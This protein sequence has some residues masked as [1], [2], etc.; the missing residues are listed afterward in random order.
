M[1]SAKFGKLGCAGTTFVFFFTL[2]LFVIIGAKGPV[3]F[4]TVRWGNG[5]NVD[6]QIMVNAPHSNGQKFTTWTG[7]VEN[8]SPDMQLMWMTLK[9]KRPATLKKDDG[10]VFSQ[11]LGVEV[12]GSFTSFD[13]VKTRSKKNI[14]DFVIANNTITRNPGWGPNRPFTD[15]QTLYNL[16]VLKY[17]YYKVNV[18]FNDVPTTPYQFSA[19][20]EMLH[21]NSQYTKFE[22][23]WKYTLLVITILVMIFPRIPPPPQAGPKC[24]VVVFVL[25]GWYTKLCSYKSAMWTNQQKWI[26]VLLPALFLFNDPLVGAYADATGKANL[27]FLAF[28]SVIFSQTFISLLL[29]FWICILEE[30]SEPP[31]H[32]LLPTVV[33]QHGVGF[34]IEKIP[35]TWRKHFAKYLHALFFWIL[36]VSSYLYYRFQQRADPTYTVLSEKRGTAEAAAAFTIIWL[37][38][39]CLWFSYY[40]LRGIK[41]IM[42]LKAGFLLVYFLTVVT[43]IAVISGIASGAMFTLNGGGVFLGVYGI[44]NIYIWTLAFVYA[45]LNRGDASS[46]ERE[47]VDPN[48][49]AGK[50]GGLA[51]TDD[52]NANNAFRNRQLEDDDEL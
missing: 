4:K 23:G 19:V 3:P 45:P 41:N 29:S 30:M 17:P 21:V 51:A 38:G 7:T 31:A 24:G 35:P 13:D 33:L 27:E 10:L 42:H 14:K 1:E 16:L 26:S 36:T 48:A 44:T 2:F 5:T 43:A 25:E 8:I 39:Y 52:V 12:Y 47:V 32:G 15:S 18:Q 34:V 6:N 50:V 9:Y 20:I 28:L 37:I 49:E 11:T 40:L 22:V 46:S